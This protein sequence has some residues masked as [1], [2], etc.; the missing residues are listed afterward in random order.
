L[1]TPERPANATHWSTRTLAAAVG[2]SNASVLCIWYAHGLK[3]RRVE[4]FKISNDPD[5]SA[6]L[7]A[8]ACPY[9]NPPEHAVVLC[10]D[11]ALNNSHS[12]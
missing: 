5:F 2:I 7:E 8:T 9:M 6:R 11:E 12:V 3:P 4:H 1:T 10:V